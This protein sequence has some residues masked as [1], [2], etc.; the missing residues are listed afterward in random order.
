MR[1]SLNRRILRL[2]IPSTIA[3][4]SVPLIG[5]VDTAMI[6]HL[7]EV[8]YLGAVSVASVIFDVIY[9][10]FGFL[11]M[12]TTALTAQYYGANQIKS[13][14]RVFSVCPRPSSGPAWG[15]ARLQRAHDRPVRNAFPEVSR[16][17]LDAH[18]RLLIEPESVL[19]HGVA[20]I[21][22]PVFP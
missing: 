2:G 16:R 12:G 20:V 8:A 5:I 22:H 7:P 18:F 4:L 15:L 13:C 9:W 21:T 17:A 19:N 11:R 10:G 6:G 3:T 1:A 14:T